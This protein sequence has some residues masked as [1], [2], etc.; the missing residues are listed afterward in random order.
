MQIINNVK[1]YYSV[2]V[3]NSQHKSAK[4]NWNLKVIIKHVY[5]AIVYNVGKIC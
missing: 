2:I 3:V 4:E 5:L 1:F